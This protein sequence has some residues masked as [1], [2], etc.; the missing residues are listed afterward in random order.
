[1]RLQIEGPEAFTSFLLSEREW[2]TETCAVVSSEICT[3]YL[4]GYVCGA[5]GDAMGEGPDEEE[6]NMH[7]A[8]KWAAQLAGLERGTAARD[9][10]P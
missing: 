8:M 10:A 6:C 9:I 5:I 1:M 7:D 3:A 4:R 2:M